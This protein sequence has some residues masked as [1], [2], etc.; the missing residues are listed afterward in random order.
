MND[1]ILTSTKKPLG[2]DASYTAFDED[3]IMHIN[4]V[5]AT[6]N[7]LGIG[8]EAGFSIENADPTWTDYLLGNERFNFI[9]SYMY[10]RV[11]LLFDPPT[12]SFHLT[13]MKDQQQEFEWRLSV[14]REGGVWNVN[15]PAVVE[16]DGGNAVGG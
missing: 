12:T 8:P 6:L 9:K 2:L 1:S 7:Q 3:I 13:A 14:L 4:S 11:R 5:F 16:L 10:L 15:L